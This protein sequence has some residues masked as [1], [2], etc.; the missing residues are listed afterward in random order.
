MGRHLIIRASACLLS[1]SDCSVLQILFADL[2]CSKEAWND[3]PYP[4][5]LRC[6]LGALNQLGLDGLNSSTS[7]FRLTRDSVS[8]ARGRYHG[9][10]AYSRYLDLASY[11]LEHRIPEVRCFPARLI[12]ALS[13]QRKMRTSVL[14]YFRPGEIEIFYLYRI[15]PDLCVLAVAKSVGCGTCQDRQLNGPVAMQRIA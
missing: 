5:H 15:E 2:K 9:V 8:V 6:Q 1:L 10:R 4:R 12:S 3:M 7:R 13:E 14:W 11:R